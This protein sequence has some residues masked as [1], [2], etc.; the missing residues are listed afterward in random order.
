MGSSYA[1]LE[2]E[3]GVQAVLKIILEANP[4]MNGKFLNIYVPGWEKAS[5]PNQYDGQELPW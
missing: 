3:T 2:V 4:E 5:G 1:D